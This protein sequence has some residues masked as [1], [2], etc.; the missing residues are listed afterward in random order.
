[1]IVQAIEPA[2]NAGATKWTNMHTVFRTAA[3]YGPVLSSIASRFD[4]PLCIQDSMPL[5]DQP[6]VKAAACV[7]TILS[8]GWQREDVLSFLRSPVG[9]CSRLEAQC[10]FRAALSRAIRDG[11]ENWRA[12]AADSGESQVSSCI[13]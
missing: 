8:Q 2:A 5:I 1:M 13:L 3:E 9:G 11:V 10:L 6:I 7:L 12:L 4:V